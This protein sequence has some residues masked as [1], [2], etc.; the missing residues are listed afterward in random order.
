MNLRQGGGYAIIAVC[1][2]FVLPVC[3]ITAKLISR[4]HWKLGIMIVPTS[5]KNWLTFGG[6]PVPDTDSGSFSHFPHH[7]RI[8]NFTYLLALLIQSPPDFHDTRQND[9]RRQGIQNISGA[10]GRHP[11]PNL[12]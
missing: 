4:F 9:W 5:R 6:D 12:D 2:S 1:L 10:I 8:E 3:R 7:C 11:G